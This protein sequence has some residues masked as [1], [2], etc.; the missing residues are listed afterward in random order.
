M[1]MTNK[2]K[3][4]NLVIMPQRLVGSRNMILDVNQ[5]PNERS[6]TISRFNQYRSG[7]S[8]RNSR[9]GTANKPASHFEQQR[10][11]ELRQKDQHDFF[12]GAPKQIVRNVQ[13]KQAENLKSQASSVKE[14]EPSVVNEHEPPRP[15]HERGDTSDLSNPLGTISPKM[16]VETG[17]AGKI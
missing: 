15:P 11:S 3:D 1:K 17:N 10:K 5:T 2:V 14:E 4:L 8:S 13:V 7:A 16:K 9:Y 12:E 6:A